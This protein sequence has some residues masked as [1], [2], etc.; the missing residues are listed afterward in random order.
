ML[1]VRAYVRGD[2]EAIAALTGA[3]VAWQDGEGPEAFAGAGFTI[4]RGLQRVACAGLC[5]IWGGRGYAW[6]VPGGLS[7]R[8][9]VLVRRIMRHKLMDIGQ[10]YGRIEC[11]IL[12]DHPAHKSFAASLGFEF[13][14]LLRKCAPGNVGDYE[15]WGRIQP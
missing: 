11:H 7:K 5:H 1:E 4:W 15:L 10:N 12:P 3:P 13:E 9:M 8:D 14:A 2:I 6:F